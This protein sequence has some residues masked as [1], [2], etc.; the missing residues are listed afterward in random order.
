MTFFFHELKNFILN[1]PLS[2]WFSI[3]HQKYQCFDKDSKSSFEIEI[4]EKTTKYKEDFFK[5]LQERQQY[6]FEFNLD[7]KQTNEFISMKQ[8]GIF[9]H[10]SLYHKE[11]D[12]LIKPD[13]IIHRDIFREIFNQVDEKLPEYIVIDILYKIIHFNTDKTDILNQGDIFYHKCK[14]LIASQCVNLSYKQGYFFAK[15]YRYK[16]KRIPKKESIGIFNFSDEM[17]NKI[18][19]ALQWR[20]KLM[21]HYEDW[22]IKPEPSVKELY[23]NMNIKTGLWNKEKKL[24]A[25]EIKEITSVW[26]ISYQK[27]CILLEKGIKTWDDPILLH[28]IYPYEIK[29][30]KREFIQE[31]MIH[32][33]SQDEL[34]IQP[35]RLKNTEFI[36][37]IQNQEDSI[38]LDIESVLY[39]DE[40]ESY[41]TDEIKL[42]D[43][44]KIC[45]IGTIL[46]NHKNIFK[47]FTIKY[48]T[49]MEEEKIIQYWLNFLQ[50][51][52]K[53]SIKIYHWGNAEKVY[54]EYMM[55]KYPDLNYPEF[56]L[57]DLVKY[58]KE[59]PIT[60]QGCFGYGLKEIVKQ[61]YSHNLIENQWTDDTDGLEA[62][63]QIMKK[64]EEASEKKIPLKRFTEIKKI[65]YYNYMD[66]KVI[67]D[68]L[69]MLQKMI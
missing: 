35:R 23:P 44:P 5:F 13:L 3:V 17:E 52:F 21:N 19:D 50:K 41:F 12:I 58:F 42:D 32:I 45:I 54:L 9:I 61:L 47:D 66:C 10:C 67:S 48:L 37:H 18:L 49:N 65:I 7:H 24:L 51:Y 1:D 46:L 22:I 26:N 64:S 11:Y 53:K 56:E 31:K 6:H 36:H 14:M 59:E 16:D 63:I 4:E 15:E 20:I 68:I 34:K 30:S 60:I 39:L 27:R 62:M 38:I 28:N 55:K 43:S 2:D 8:I 57:V 25:D 40:K 29:E 33:N 69:I